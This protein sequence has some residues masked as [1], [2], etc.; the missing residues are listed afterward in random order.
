MKIVLLL[1]IISLILQGTDC[2]G[3][4]LNVHVHFHGGDYEQNSEPEDDIVADNR[5]RISTYKDTMNR[6]GD[7]FAKYIETVKQDARDYE[8][9]TGWGCKVKVDWDNQKWKRY[10]KERDET[11]RERAKQ[12]YERRLAEFKRKTRDYEKR[13]GYECEVHED[14]EK[15][16]IKRNC[17]RRFKNRSVPLRQEPMVEV[18][19]K[20]RQ[21]VTSSDD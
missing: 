17:V 10:C 12:E 19:V 7:W 8:K 16:K 20:P 6:G 11:V 1:S 18:K 2:L 21:I 15:F 3:E 13:T 9:K 5:A 14:P 4:E